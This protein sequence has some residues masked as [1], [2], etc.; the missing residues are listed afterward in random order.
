M[1]GK[2]K[3]NT[4]SERV[5]LNEREN[6]RSSPGNEP[7]QLLFSGLD[8]KLQKTFTVTDF[9]SQASLSGL[10]NLRMSGFFRTA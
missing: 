3:E 10:G 6:R 4:M 7:G 1:Y 8:G 2:G 5:I 9:I